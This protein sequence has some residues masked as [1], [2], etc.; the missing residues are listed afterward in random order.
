[1][2]AAGA[3]V[4]VSVRFFASLRETLGCEQL[5][6]HLPGQLAVS[7]LIAQVAEAVVEVEATHQGLAAG[8]RA[9]RVVEIRSRLEAA[10]VRL[11]HNQSLHGASELKLQSG[12]QLAFLPPVTGG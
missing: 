2:S 11:A 7:E 10:N 4:S 8:R 6:L 1:M 9:G 12:D 3:P 5:A